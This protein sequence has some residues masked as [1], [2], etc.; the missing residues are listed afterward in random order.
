MTQYTY[1]GVSGGRPE[2]QFVN[3][4]IEQK[5]PPV[6]ARS[7]LGPAHAKLSLSQKSQLKKLEL[8]D[9]VI[10]DY[11][12]KISLR[13]RVV[14]APAE[15]ALMSHRDVPGVNGEPRVW[16]RFRVSGALSLSALADKIMLPLMGWYGV[17]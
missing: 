7:S 15:Q 8:G 2:D 11:V 13:C 14:V 9:L 17:S 10:R 3:F 12:L 5:V 16:R 4:L 1:S 6:E